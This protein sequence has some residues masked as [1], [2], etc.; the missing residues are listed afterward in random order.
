L[1]TSYRIRRRFF[2]FDSSIWSDSSFGWSLNFYRSPGVSNSIITDF[3]FVCLIPFIS[4]LSVLFYPFLDSLYLLILLLLISFDVFFIV[5]LSECLFGALYSWARWELLV[6]L[7]YVGARW[8]S[9]SRVFIVLWYTEYLPCTSE[10][11][12]LYSIMTNSISSKQLFMASFF[13]SCS[14]CLRQGFASSF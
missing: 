12:L 5:A 10:S 8:V 9:F 2:F 7:A 3:A 14:S 1:S 13:S 11:A 6:M 4:V